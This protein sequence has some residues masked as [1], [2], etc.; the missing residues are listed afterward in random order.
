MWPACRPVAATDGVNVSSAEKWG[1]H[2]S[3]ARA[4]AAPFTASKKQRLSAIDTC[5]GYCTQQVVPACSTRCKMRPL[6]EIGATGR[7]LQH[8]CTTVA[9]RAHRRDHCAGVLLLVNEQHAAALPRMPVH[10]WCMHHVLT[11]VPFTAGTQSQQMIGY[12]AIATA[13]T[14]WVAALVRLVYVLCARRVATAF[15]RPH[16]RDRA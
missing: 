4:D 16:R 9:A 5:T 15:C 1:L 12:Y 7:Y 3:K 6:L 10:V 14:V 8:G 2:R 13:K 11:S